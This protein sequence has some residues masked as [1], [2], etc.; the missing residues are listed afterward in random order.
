V[1][2]SSTNCTT[3]CPYSMGHR[4]SGVVCVKTR[5]NRALCCSLQW[6]FSSW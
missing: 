3:V 2:E 4:V 5:M 1:T 6:L